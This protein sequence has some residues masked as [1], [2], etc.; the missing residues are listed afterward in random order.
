MADLQKIFDADAHILLAFESN[1]PYLDKDVLARLP[2]L[3]AFK[4]SVKTQR[5]GQVI[6]PLYHRWY[7]FTPGGGRPCHR[8]VAGP[9][10]ES[11]I[12]PFHSPI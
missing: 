7:R 10:K 6:E 2:E 1:V 11:S 8:G 4:S 9:L 5:A 12:C 3:E